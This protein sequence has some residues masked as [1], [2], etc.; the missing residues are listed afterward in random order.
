MP[1][2]PEERYLGN[3]LFNEK[4][5]HLY[6]FGGKTNE[7]INDSILVLNLKCTGGWD[8]IFLK[9]NSKLL[10]RFNSISFHFNF[11]GDED[12]IYICGGETDEGEEIEFIVEY[13]YETNEVKKTGIE[14]KNNPSFNI[15]T[16]IDRNRNLFTFV[17]SNENIYILKKDYF[18]INIFNQEDA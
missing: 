4:N 16:V 13:N 14:S 17:D 9:E 10:K 8:K 5:F 3:V 18:S 11:N 15:S 2:L 12:Y 6:L 7:V 1:L